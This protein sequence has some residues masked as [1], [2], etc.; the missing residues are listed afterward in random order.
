M[1]ATKKTI[2]KKSKTATS[3]LKART[4]GTIVTKRKGVI[5][6]RAAVTAKKRKSA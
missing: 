4:V 3:G 6:K 2:E 5:A 1:A